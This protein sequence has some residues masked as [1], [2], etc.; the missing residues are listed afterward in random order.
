M[1]FQ[2]K[3][4]SMAMLSAC[5]HMAAAQAPN[6][7]SGGDLLRQATPQKPEEI[8]KNLPIVEAAPYALP[9]TAKDT[10][11]VQVKGFRLTG[12]TAFKQGKIEQLLESHVGQELGVNKLQAIASSITKLYRDHG[13]F[14]A[15]AYLPEQRLTDG[16]VTI[17]IVEGQYGDFKIDNASLVTDVE[18]QAFMDKL[19][20]EKA[21]ST[22]TLER[23]LLLINDLSGVVVVNAEFYP[24]KA[25]G[26]SDFGIKTQ[27]TEKISGYAI[28]DNYGARYTGEARLSAGLSVNS[29]TGI[30]D[31][32]S[33]NGL[34]SDTSDLQNHGLSYDRPLGYGGWKGGGSYSFSQFTLRHVQNYQSSGVT[35]NFGLYASYPL[36]KTRMQTQEIRF[37]LV[38][39][40]MEDTS[41]LIGDVETGGKST[42]G[43]SISFSDKR[44]T[45]FFSQ[46]G[47]LFTTLSTTFGKAR[48]DNAVSLVN[49]ANLKSAGS[50]SKA[51]LRVTHL[52]QIDL[53]TSLN[54]VLKAQT[55]FGR[56]LDSSEDMSVGGS[57]GLRAYEDS[58][59]SGDKG[60]V[61]SMDLAYSLPRYQEINHQVALI[62]DVA[63]VWKNTRVFNTEANSRR[64][65]DIG[66]GYAM[67]YRNFDLKVSLA[68]GYGPNRTP[69]SE[70]EFSTNTTKF[71]VQGM[72]RF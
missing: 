62:F 46:Q 42:D 52:Q 60:V 26:T 29:L 65:Y 43:L 23:Q 51:N 35:R 15:R 11:M 63:Q 44:A 47:R 4:L 39:R 61:L 22:Q 40:K 7:P 49:D 28:A 56:N 12:N 30:G 5:A 17:A 24:G 58:E 48:M 3:L 10:V 64:L 55:N 59:L 16:I 38:H 70:A 8:G 71:L 6:L 32:F 72:F 69:T 36:L 21:I 34:V 41:G 19:K 50:Y 31:S 53:R 33:A 1:N 45:N 20:E 14:V 68:R 27:A 66:I 37:D 25:V 18:V 13:Y 54:T 57:N 2:L 67:N 9:L